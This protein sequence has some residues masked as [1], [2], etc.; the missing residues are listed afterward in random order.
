MN[1]NDITT[2]LAASVGNPSV[3]PVADA[4]PTM[5]AAL[6]EALNPT[7]TKETRVLTTPETRN[8]K[9]EETND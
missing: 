5:A 3:G 2:I 7:P 8:N 9:D 6:A 4:I 1:T